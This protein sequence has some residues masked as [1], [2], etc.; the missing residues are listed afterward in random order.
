MPHGDIVKLVNLEIRD[1]YL[2][3]AV[4]LRSTN[5]MSGKGCKNRMSQENV[6]LVM[7]PISK[8][9][10]IFLATIAIRKYFRD[11]LLYK[12]KLHTCIGQNMK[13]I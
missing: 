12:K 13:S 11:E 3:T 10:P 9:D 6:K 2:I 7:S 8:S 1:I 4:L 5:M